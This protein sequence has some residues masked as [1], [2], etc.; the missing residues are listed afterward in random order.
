[1]TP[2]RAAERSAHPGLDEARELLVQIPEPDPPSTIE[3]S[4]TI[5]LWL[6]SIGATTASNLRPHQRASRGTSRSVVDRA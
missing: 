5:I 1:M 3:M 6:A 2:D 4:S